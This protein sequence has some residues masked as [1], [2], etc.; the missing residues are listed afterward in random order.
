VRG[1]AASRY[2]GDHVSVR[3]IR[4]GSIPFGLSVLI[5][6]QPGSLIVWLLECE[7]P[8]ATAE[9]LERVLTA[10]YAADGESATALRRDLHPV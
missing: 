9:L 5:D 10:V 7:W 4:V 2:R 1:A 3:V 6:D 8:E